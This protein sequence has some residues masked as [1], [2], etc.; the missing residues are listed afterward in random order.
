[1]DYK[2]EKLTETN[3]FPVFTGSN[4]L[5]EVTKSVI[6][7]V[8]AGVSQRDGEAYEAYKRWKYE[9]TVL[10]GDNAG[11]KVWKTFNLD[12]EIRSGKKQKTP[13]ENLMDVLFTLGLPYDESQFE[14]SNEKF[15]EMKLRVSFNKI[16]AARAS[17]G[18][19]VQLHT[20]T[21]V[22]EMGAAEQI[23]KEATEF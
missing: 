15:A 19:D 16:P 3:D 1:M 4:L 9:L 22:D 20:I 8:P 12:S 10:D 23:G 6:E 17:G 7:D 18:K 2:P 5:C 11:R 14:D 21:G 13:K